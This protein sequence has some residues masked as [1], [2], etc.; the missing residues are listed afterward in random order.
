[1]AANQMQAFRVIFTG[2]RSGSSA[3]TLYGES[4]AQVRG[5]ITNVLGEFVPVDF[6]VVEIPTIPLR[7]RLHI[8]CFAWERRTWC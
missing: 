8:A 3:V 5:W 4:E 2:E 6:E 1:M 7:T